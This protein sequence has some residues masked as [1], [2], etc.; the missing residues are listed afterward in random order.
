MYWDHKTEVYKIVTVRMKTLSVCI[1]IRSLIMTLSKYERKKKLF[2]FWIHWNSL[3]NFISVLRSVPI[4]YNQLDLLESTP[5]HPNPIFSRI[6]P[7]PLWTTE[8]CLNPLQLELQFAETHSHSFQ[9]TQSLSSRCNIKVESPYAPNDRYPYL[10]INITLKIV[11]IIYYYYD[12]VKSKTWDKF[13]QKFK[14][15]SPPRS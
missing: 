3:I 15:A 7:S 10:W 8:I 12:S 6:H 4:F 14:G 5:I 1:I 2:W 9:T 13:S 11:V